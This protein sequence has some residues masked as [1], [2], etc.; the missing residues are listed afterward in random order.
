MKILKG[1]F[2]RPVKKL[3]KTVINLLVFDVAQSI[4][5]YAKTKF[6]E[7]R[8]KRKKTEEEIINDILWPEFKK[9]RRW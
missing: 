9:K 1:L 8:T 7:P 3:G 2:T 6:R 4:Y 5:L